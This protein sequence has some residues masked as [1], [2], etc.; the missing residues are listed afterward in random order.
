[1][2][3]DAQLSMQMTHVRGEVEEAG[4]EELEETDS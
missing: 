2:C 1:M 3:T 4:W